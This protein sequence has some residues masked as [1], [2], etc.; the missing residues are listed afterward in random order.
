MHAF[1]GVTAGPA[2]CD[3]GIRPTYR[4]LDEKDRTTQPTGP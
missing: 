2:A 4:M 1:H 3:V